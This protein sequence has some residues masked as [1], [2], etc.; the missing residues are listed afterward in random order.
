MPIWQRL[1]GSLAFHGRVK[2]EKKMMK[3]VPN[4]ERKTVGMRM[5]GV[6]AR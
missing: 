1:F 4:M 2:S 5:E 3:D 6:A